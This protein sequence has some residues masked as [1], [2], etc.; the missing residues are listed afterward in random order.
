MG[1]PHLSNA[2]RQEWEDRMAM[3]DTLFS[4]LM[5]CVIAGAIAVVVSGCIWATLRFAHEIR[6]AWSDLRRGY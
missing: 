5:A 2:D 6:D 3:V 4:I 1:E